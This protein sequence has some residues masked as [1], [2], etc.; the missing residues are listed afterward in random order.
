[1]ATAPSRDAVASRCGLR[2]ELTPSAPRPIR[3][4]NDLA[5]AWLKS[6]RRWALQLLRSSAVTAAVDAESLRRERRSTT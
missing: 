3:V 6:G 4:A 1:M 2:P 5:G